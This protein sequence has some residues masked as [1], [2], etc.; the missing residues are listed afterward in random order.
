[1]TWVCMSSTTYLRKA[2]E[3]FIRDEVRSFRGF[4]PT[5]RLN[6]GGN[7]LKRQLPTGP[8]LAFSAILS[9]VR[10]E[11]IFFRPLEPSRIPE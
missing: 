11:R 7:M 6:R 9:L 2:G 4:S 10:T 3:I 8:I 5:V 1:M